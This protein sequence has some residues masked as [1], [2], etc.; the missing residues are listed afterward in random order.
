MLVFTADGADTARAAAGPRPAARSAE[1]A[2]PGVTF[3]GDSWTQGSGAGGLRGY[4]VRAAEQLGWNY[5]IL[6]VGGS[7]YSV[8]GSRGTFGQRIDGAVASDPDVI[9]VQGSLN[10]RASTV[11]RLL[12]G[13]IETLA[14]LRA[15]AEPETRILVL[16]ASNTPGKD[17]ATIDWING[18]VAAAAA[19]AGLTFVDVAAENWTDPGQPDIWADPNHPNDLGH[20]LIADRLVPLLRSLVQP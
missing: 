10:E 17:P 3:V 4:A 20:Q 12:P 1:T 16:G 5:R 14:E 15:A 9:V 13:A 8:T 18:A 2:V 19:A 11:D 6:G 7:G